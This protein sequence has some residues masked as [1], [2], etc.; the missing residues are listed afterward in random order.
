MPKELTRT[1]LPKPLPFKI[2]CKRYKQFIRIITERMSL[3]VNKANMTI[4]LQDGSEK[5]ICNLSCIPVHDK[6]CGKC[7]TFK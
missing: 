2:H 7:I 6:L 1:I 4:T 5:R 3:Q